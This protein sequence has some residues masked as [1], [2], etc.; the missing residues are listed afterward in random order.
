MSTQYL[1]DYCVR[2]LKEKHIPYIVEPKKTETT[3]IDC[4]NFVTLQL[5]LILNT[6][7]NYIFIKFIAEIGATWQKTT[8]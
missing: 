8:V 5:H 3:T 4:T 1:S 2:E 6:N 7:A